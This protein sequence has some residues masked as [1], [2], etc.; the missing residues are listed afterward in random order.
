MNHSPDIKAKVALEAIREEMA[1]AELAKKYSVHPTQ[2]GTWKRAAIKNM[3]TAYAMRG[4]KPG[5]DDGARI[6]TLHTKIG[7]R[8]VERDFLPMPPISCSGREAKMVSRTYD[9]GVRCKAQ[10]LILLAARSDN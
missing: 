2:I 9:L 5:R 6:E 3:A 1:M 7:L 10:G 4:R 8:V